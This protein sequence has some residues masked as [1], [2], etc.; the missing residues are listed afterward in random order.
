MGGGKSAGNQT[1]TNTNTPWSGVQPGLQQLYGLGNQWLY[2]GNAPQPQNSQAPTTGKSGGINNTVQSTPGMWNDAYANQQGTPIGLQFK[3]ITPAAPNY[4][5]GYGAM[6]NAAQSNVAGLPPALQAA[7]AMQ[8][9]QALQGNQW[10]PTLQNSYNQM[11]SG[12]YQNDPNY[13]FQAQQLGRTFNDIT[14]PALAAQFGGRAGNSNQALAF[15]Q[16]ANELGNALSGLSAQTYNANANR[17]LQAMQLAPQ[18]QQLPYYDIN[19]LG[20]VG[21]AQRAY[22]QQLLSAPYQQLTQYAQLLQPGLGYGTQTQQTPLYK[23]PLAGGIGG[24]ASG[25]MI[26]S[27]IPGLGT[28][29]GAGIGGALGLLGSL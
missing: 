15:G 21:E 13:Q 5:Q 28:G 14:M 7:Y 8:T 27:A 3:S 17:Q 18:M 1:S 2:G 22:Q 12:N 6:A 16:Q 23:N 11:L 26:G 9:R 20:A 10:M 4:Q 19:Q 29:L 25:A 24:A